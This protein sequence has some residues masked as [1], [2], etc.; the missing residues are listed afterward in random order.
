MKATD[1][2]FQQEAKDDI[3]AIAHHIAED[4]PEATERFFVALDTLCDLL[5]HTPEMG[6]MRIFQSPRLQDM[7]IMPLQNFEKYMVF[8]RFTGATIEILR[9]IHGA[10]DYPVF[11]E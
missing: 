1:L 7:R 4:N 11:F 9:V 6:S 3:N 10:R 8:Y 2:I 5:I